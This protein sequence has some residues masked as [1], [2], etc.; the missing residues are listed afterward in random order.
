VN[1]N[2]REI[3]GPSLLTALGAAYRPV[4]TNCNSS[5]SPSTSGQ[6]V[7][8]GGGNDSLSRPPETSAKE[9]SIK[10]Q[11]IVLLLFLSS[12]LY[13]ALFRNYTVFNADEGVIL[14]GAERVLAGQVLYRDFFSF[15]TPG[16]F[17][18]MAFLFRI[19]GNS[20]LVARAALVLYGGVFAALTYLLARRVCARW[21]SLLAAS[22]VTLTC[23][24][25][26]FVILHN[27]DSTL[28]AY[29]SLYCAVLLVENR[30]WAWAWAA[31]SFAALT[32]LFEQSKGSGLIIGLLAAWFLIR[33]CSRGDRFPGRK[34]VIAT[35]LGFLWP[36][37]L[38]FGYFAAKHSVREMAADWTWA[39]FH[40]SAANKL[41]YGFVV[42]STPDAAGVLSGS[43]ASKAIL[44]I[45]VGPFFFIPILPF[46]AAAI[47]LWLVLRRFQRKTLPPSCE[48]WL[49]VSAVLSGLLLSTLLTRRADF[50]HLN[51]LG[52][53]FYLVLAWVLDGLRLPSRLWRASVPAVVYYSVLSITFFGLTLLIPVLNADHRISTVR[54][55]IKT[56]A[57][58]RALEYVQAHTNPGENI[59]VYPYQP[60]FY[61]LTGTFSATGF[62]YLQPGMHTAGQ[63]Q[64]ALQQ[65]AAAPP[66]VV[67]FETSFSDN[68][69][70]TWP[71]TP[72]QVFVA[73][74]PIEKF[75]FA[76]YRPCTVLV[77][78]G[79]WHFVFL[80]RKDKHCSDDEKRRSGN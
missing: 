77:A 5:M 1:R 69:S 15:Y 34:Q 67:L 17:Y 13:L 9:R 68:Y 23:L 55:V 59:F 57:P 61:Y 18:W 7:T 20:M 24:P 52:P 41:P 8:S 26:R 4:Q 75:V 64:E 3:P 32:F 62:D 27:W 12:C 45:V 11:W 44:A 35:M 16:S 49:L 70:L 28:L 25:Y 56:G 48:Y 78:N 40:Y 58:D 73:G 71:N 29:L 22:A 66:R 50:T 76:N 51:Y 6:I 2:D 10:D 63:F 65:L 38:T 31:G 36:F 53:L 80:V 43:W 46:A 14:Q 19:F 60:S 74:D 47:L 54:G 79:F 42:L 21:S 72:V 37:A 30:H 33:W 39:V